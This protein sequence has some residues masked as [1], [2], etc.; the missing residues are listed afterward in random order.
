MSATKARTRA[1][2]LTDEQLIRVVTD[3]SIADLYPNGTAFVSSDVQ[4]VDTIVADLL[5]TGSP[6]AIIAENGEEM[7]IVPMPERRLLGLFRRSRQYK[8][9]IRNLADGK[10]R[11][12]WTLEKARDIS[13][14]LTQ[15]AVS[16][17]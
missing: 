2:R 15:P 1:D 17:S 8:V 4:G 6:M 13:V 16:A 10:P 9:V 7:L 14:I 5:A 11:T 3:D 12:L